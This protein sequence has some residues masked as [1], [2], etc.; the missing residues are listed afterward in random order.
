MLPDK[1]C[2]VDVETT[3]MRPNYD[4][5]IEIGIL[6]VENGKLVK[7]YQTLINPGGYVPPEI[8]SI[9][10]ISPAK[11]E[12]APHFWEV[13]DEILE[14]LADTVFVAHNVRFDYSFLKSE[15]KRVGRNFSPKH[16]CTVKLSRSLFPNYSHHN[17]DAIIQ[18]FNIKCKNRHRA[19]DD[20]KVLWDF[21]KKAQK[22][23]DEVTFRL[24]LNKALKR[25]SVPIRLEQKI[26]DALPESP[27]V[28]IFYGENGIPLYVGKSINIR[29]RVLSHF[30][31]DIHS[32]KEM[33]I[34]RQVE[35]IEAIKTAGE[36][37]AL[38][39]E[40]YLVK[41]LQPVY[42]RKLRVSRKMV[43]LKTSFNEDGYQKVLLEDTGMIDVSEVNNILGVFRSKKQAK[44]FL[45]NLARDYSL[46]EKLLGTENTKGECFGF[47]LGRCKG[48]CQAKER[49]IFY[50]V[51]CMEAFYRTKLKPWPFEGSILIKEE[52]QLEEKEEGFLIDKWCYLGRVSKDDKD[53]QKDYIF[54]LDT[55]KILERHLRNPD[56]LKGVKMVG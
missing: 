16:F 13:R 9:T 8:V 56:N 36:L 50:N 41:K 23:V 27:G 6:R 3:G 38:L 43:I 14:M 53:V 25:P 51:R 54:D 47:R 21:I 32:S 55:Y 12:N 45:I 34:S 29:E 11:L 18:H 24:A 48:A 22:S 10:G 37:G 15:F 7:T 42:N 5:V 49:P 20:A 46:C 28:Y 35:S 40:A 30:S 26:L 19:F 39:K 33:Q 52:D 44:D 4:R 17:L 2:F 31:Q 1:I